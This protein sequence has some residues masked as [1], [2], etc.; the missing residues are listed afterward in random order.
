[1]GVSAIVFA[2]TLRYFY[3]QHQWRSRI[4]SESEAK[5]QA[6]QSRIR[7]HF[8]FNNMNTIA[9]LAV[10]NPNWRNKL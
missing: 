3:I 7:S 5:Y 2:L 1:M 9:S 6:L 10:D 4:R 8:L